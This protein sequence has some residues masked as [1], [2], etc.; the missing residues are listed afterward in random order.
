[1]LRL[2][3]FHGLVPNFAPLLALAML[4]T[5]ADTAGADTGRRE[6]FI[7]SLGLGP[8]AIVSSIEYEID[9]LKRLQAGTEFCIGYAPSDQF[10]LHYAGRALWILA[11]A[12]VATPS[13]GANY[14]F[15]PEAPSWFITGGGGAVFVA[16]MRYYDLSDPGKNIFA[17]AGYEWAPHW[18]AAL[19]WTH[20]WWE[21]F[22]SNVD[23]VRLTLSY[24]AY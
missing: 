1:M 10:H 23:D 2:S 24:L 21:D 7:L 5:C 17:G 14:Y 12:V 15:S 19:E 18:R 11:Y 8:S 16:H 6:G 4:L 22:D 9:D 13:L 20:Y 3:G